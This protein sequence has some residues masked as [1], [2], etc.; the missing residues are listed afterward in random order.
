MLGGCREA[1]SGGG[2]RFLYDNELASPV[3][4]VKHLCAATAIVYRL[5]RHVPRLSAIEVVGWFAVVR[6]SD[7]LGA[8]GCKETSAQSD[9]RWVVPGVGRGL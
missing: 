5:L 1:A 2:G 8:H 6:A 4:G 9:L 3:A 7:R